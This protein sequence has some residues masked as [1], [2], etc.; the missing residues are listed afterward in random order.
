MSLP[1]FVDDGIHLIF[2]HKD[3]KPKRQNCYW[4]CPVKFVPD[5]VWGFL[6]MYNTIKAFPSIQLPA[7]DDMHPRFLTAMYYYESHYNEYLTV[8]LENK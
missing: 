4:N 6:K 1:T 5:N 2:D 8:K 3:Y 7:F